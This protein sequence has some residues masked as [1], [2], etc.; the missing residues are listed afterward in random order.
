[1]TPEQFQELANTRYGHRLADGSPVVSLMMDPSGANGATDA[2]DLFVSVVER[3]ANGRRWAAVKADPPTQAERQG[4]LAR[5]WGRFVEFL[6]DEGGAAPAAKS[7]DPTTFEAALYPRAIM[8]A[9]WRGSDALQTAIRGIFEDEGITDKEAAI[10]KATAAFAAYVNASAKAPALKAE[11]VQK[12]KAA[13]IA[14]TDQPDA[15]PL[16]AKVGRMISARNAGRLRTSAEAIQKAIADLQALLDENDAQIDPATKNAPPLEDPMDKA[17]LIRAATLAAKA[18]NPKLTDA[19]AV[20][21]GLEA[22]GLAG[23]AVK[24]DVGEPPADLARLLQESGLLA[25]GSPMLPDAIASAILKLPAMKW[26]ADRIQALETA[27]NGTPAAKSADGKE[28]EAVPGLREVA[29]KGLAVS[30]GLAER[31]RIPRAPASAGT[32]EEARQPAKKGDGADDDDD[33]FKGSGLS[34]LG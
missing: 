25:G 21:V 22:A 18:A 33:T 15:D 34:F 7:S 2:T 13:A 32:P 8:D 27:I 26:M 20:A 31:L 3:G 23:V 1:M 16:A 14:I 30:V 6:G 29:E 4:T 24:A 9:I 12:I 17:E 11:D 28:I 10:A 5:A 19:Q